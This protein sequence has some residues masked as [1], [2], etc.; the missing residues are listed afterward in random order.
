MSAQLQ[1]SLIDRSTLPVSPVDIEGIVDL[2]ANAQ[3]DY[4]SIGNFST[5]MNAFQRDFEYAHKLACGIDK[6]TM[7][8]VESSYK[9]QFRDIARGE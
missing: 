6:T 3:L 7:E 5:R 1:S 9:S 8:K 4:S 2:F